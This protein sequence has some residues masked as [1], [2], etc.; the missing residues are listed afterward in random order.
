MCGIFAY[1][2]HEVDKDR[3]YIL[4]V[5]LKGLRQLEYRG[6]DSA[7]ISID[8]DWLEEE[9]PLVVDGIPMPSPPPLLFRKEGKISNLVSEVYTGMALLALNFVLSHFKQGV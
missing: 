6:Y 7:G 4:E 8:A 5:L 3:R 1:L 9:A 2:N